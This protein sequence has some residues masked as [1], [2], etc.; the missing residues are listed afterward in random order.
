[1]K[2]RPLLA[3][4]LAALGAVLLLSA[5]VTLLFFSGVDPAGKLSTTGWV[6]VAKALLGAAAVAGALVAGSPGGARRFFTGRAAHFGFFTVVSAALVVAI[7]AALNW[8]AWA[9][10]KTWDLTKD[11]LYT[12][13]PDTVA[14]L[15]RL[16][17]DVRALAFYL[18]SEPEHAAAEDLFR[19]YAARSPRFTWEIVDPYA[20]PE[21]VKRWEITDRSTRIVLVSG[22]KDVRVRAPTEEALTNGLVQLAGKSG[23][24]AYFVTGHGEPPPSGGGDRGYGAA[25]EG[26]RQ[27]GF[28]VAPL[29][30]LERGEVP[31]DATVVVE[32]G[33]RKPLL[34]PEVK[35]LRAFLERGGKVGVFL[36]PG[37]DAGLDGLL[38][39]W[40]VEAADDLVL[41]PSPVAQLF[42]GSAST[43]M[44]VPTGRH[45][46]TKGM[47]QVGLA[48]PTAR[49]LVALTKAAVAPTPVVLTAET[50]WAETDVKGAFARRPVRPDPGE[51]R[52]PFPVA[53]AASRAIAG[54]PAGREARLVV[55][56][57]SEFFDDRY[58][59]VLGNLDFFQ[60]AIAW[61][62]EQPDR[63]TIRPRNREGSRLFL[64]ASQ[65]STL[66]FLTV[67]ALPLALLGAGLAVWLVRRSR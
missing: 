30:L 15:G 63:I 6:A 61:L 42:G 28:E 44:V 1:V 12:L 41:D 47:E 56:G 18:R 51:K 50:A 37:V 10:P 24:K 33:A 36:E 14:T 57:D 52:G 27:D 49:S 23:R 25:A 31:A 11:R 43:P 65:V 46:A 20:R 59:Q 55:A 29:S 34:D 8:I 35:A 48:F 54:E 2:S 60:N 17:R 40:G 4:I 22:E 32:A 3:R 26:L 19:R 21:L 7:L 13:A 66:R 67:D 53:M 64:G 5:P 58:A 39:E 16:D 38:A 45:P 9:R 62:G